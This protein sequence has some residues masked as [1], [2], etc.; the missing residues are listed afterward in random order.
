MGLMVERPRGVTGRRKPA[1]SILVSTMVLLSLVSLFT[2]SGGATPAS[3]I[4]LDVTIDPQDA[5]ACVTPGQLDTLD[6]N[7]TVGVYQPNYFRSEIHLAASVSTGWPVV[8]AVEALNIQGSAVMSFPC[9]VVVP[10]GASA[11]TTAKLTVTATHDPLGPSTV[12]AMANANITVRPYCDASLRIYPNLID[13]AGGESITL[14]GKALND[15]NANYTFKLGVDNPHSNIDTRISPTSLRIPHG[16]SVTFELE[17]SVQEGISAGL[18]A[19]VVELENKRVGNEPFIKVTETVM[20]DTNP[21]QAIMKVDP[22]RVPPGLDVTFD[23][24]GS[25]TGK[26]VPR[27]LFDFGDGINT[28]WA[29]DPVVTHAYAKEGEFTARL[30]VEGEGGIRSTNDASVVVTVTTEGFKSTAEI[31]SI[32]PN[33]APK[34]DAV[35]LT[36]RGTPVPGAN[37]VAYQWVSS[38]DGVLGGTAILTV[39]ALSSGTHTI[40]FKVQDERGMWS[41]PATADLEVLPP[42][43]AWVIQVIEPLEGARLGGSTGRVEGT[44][45]FAGVQID[46]VEV[47]IDEGPWRTTSGKFR[48]SYEFD[49]SALEDGDHTLQVR[50]HAKGAVSQ[51]VSVSFTTGPDPVFGGMMGELSWTQLALIGL[52]GLLIVGMVLF[53]RSRSHAPIL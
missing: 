17:I 5:Q 28:G 51:P 8:L 6:F 10:P 49:P 48:W 27:Y 53:A 15:G 7:C 34:N 14:E 20:V 44:A 24:S 46:K 35:T 9:T 41:E 13:L 26:G 32:S 45:E 43:S 40:R 29:S 25:T 3:V 11:D 22:R 50:G 39:T 33:P 16:E 31:V 36:G 47:R 38:I 1:V 19:L 37:I 30:T 23:A 52:L 12:S 42:L 21:V 2:T 18:H 4:D